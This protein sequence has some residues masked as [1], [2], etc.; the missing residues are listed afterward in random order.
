MI[1]LKFTNQHVLVEGSFELS[2]NLSLLLE[3]LESDLVLRHVLSFLL[4]EGRELVLDKGIRC[5]TSAGEAASTGTIFREG[6]L[7]TVAVVALAIERLGFMLDIRDRN[8][9][10]QVHPAR[11]SAASAGSEC[12]LSDC[13]PRM[14]DVSL[15]RIMAQA[16]A[17]VACTQRQIVGFAARL[18]RFLLNLGSV[19]LYPP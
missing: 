5:H 15:R 3:L 19:G 12:A 16:G 1:L 11:S 13:G 7:I 2:L 18:H 9:L 14:A 4:K 17:A 8:A 10:A 6:V